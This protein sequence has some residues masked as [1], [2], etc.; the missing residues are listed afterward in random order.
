MS[1]ALRDTVNNIRTQ[2]EIVEYC[3][4]GSSGLLNHWDEYW[5]HL[6]FAVPNFARELVMQY[7]VLVGDL[8]DQYRPSDYA[9]TMQILNAWLAE[10]GGMSMV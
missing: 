3:T 2:L 1:A 9:E 6:Q 5:E 4:L 7:I 8:Y 10:V